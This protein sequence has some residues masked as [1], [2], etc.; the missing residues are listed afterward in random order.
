LGKSQVTLAAIT[1]P[2]QS[3]NKVLAVVTPRGRLVRE[4]L[5]GVACV[6]EGQHQRHNGSSTK[7][8]EE[9]KKEKKKKKKR[10]NKGS[11]TKKK[12]KASHDV[13]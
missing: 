4:H 7:K 5:K 8:E 13:I 3:P 6:S 10:R 11:E 2:R 12:P 1:L 9:K